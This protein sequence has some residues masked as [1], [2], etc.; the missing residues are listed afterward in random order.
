[1][2]TR[3]HDGGQVGEDSSKASQAILLSVAVFP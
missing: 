1:M 2:S 3:R